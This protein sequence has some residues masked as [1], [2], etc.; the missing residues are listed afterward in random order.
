[1]VLGGLCGVVV[2]WVAV[3]AAV[4]V[5]GA[6]SAQ[7][8]ADRLRALELTIGLRELVEGDV[9]AEVAEALADFR[10]AERMFDSPWLA[11]GRLLPVA[12]RQLETATALAGSA[13]EVLQTVAG[14]LDV[15]R[16]EVEGE[17]PV[18]A[19]RVRS[20]ARLLQE[21]EVVDAA[22]GEADLGP[23][24]ALVGPLR[25]A[26]TEMAEKLAEVRSDA[27]DLLTVLEHLHGLL[28][29]PATYV[30]LAANN[31]EMRIGSGMYLSIGAVEFGDGRLVV[32]DRLTPAAEIV[33]DDGVSLSEEMESLWGWS[34]M[35]TDWRDLGL[36]GRFP[37]NAEV[38]ARMWAGLGRGEVDGVLM[39]D[40]EAVRSLLEVVGPV[41]IDGL[42]IGPD[43]ALEYLLEDQYAD[44]DDGRANAERRERL[45]ELATEVLERLGQS[46]VDLLRLVDQLRDARD[47]RHLLAWSDGPAA[48]AWRILG[49]D[50]DLDER[51]V[52]VGLANADGSKLDPFVDLTVDVTTTERDGA[53]SVELEIEILNTT[54]DGKPTYVVGTDDSA[55]YRGLLVAHVP[56]VATSVELRGLDGLA[57][58]GR[59]GRTIVV[60]AAVEVAQDERRTGTLRFVVPAGVGDLRVEPSARIPPAKWVRDGE[61]RRD[62]SA[63]E[64]TTHG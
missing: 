23:S 22:L 11:P 29:G 10:R 46:D 26:R 13:T 60:A 6:R 40:V 42:E 19:G 28:D 59:D 34:G 31:S 12:G 2:V 4:V 37:V 50:G 54:P 44:A 58:T 49:V 7:D 51:S 16:D 48:E 20:I 61:A 53:V 14:A 63:W 47:G 33:L 15:L 32:T 8:G 45:G 39:V 57:A 35:G 56:G 41:T 43:N 64:L 18:G 27:G 24:E 21:V 38:A 55:S 25:R 62:D 52:L 5:I 17:T 3:G 36:S 1:M 30:V 9:D